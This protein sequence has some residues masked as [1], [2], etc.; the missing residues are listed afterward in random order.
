MISVTK[1][2]SI[3]GIKVWNIHSLKSQSKAA[4]QL[5][6]LSHD[7]SCFWMNHLS[8]GSLRAHIL[9][10]LLTW[11]NADWVS[12]ILSL[13]LYRFVCCVVKVIKEDVTNKV[14]FISFNGF[15]QQTFVANKAASN[16]GRISSTAYQHLACV[17][18]SASHGQE[19]GNASYIWPMTMV[20]PKGS[21]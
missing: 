5:N 21:L 7:T 16:I 19:A 14:L 12:W 4:S 10:K 17:H 11:H 20:T 18:F 2:A 6:K 13:W 3:Y 1:L 15:T 9:C 8:P